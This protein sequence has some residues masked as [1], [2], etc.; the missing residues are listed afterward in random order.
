MKY[1][2]LYISQSDKDCSASPLKDPGDGTY[3]FDQDV[4]EA[5][6]NGEADIFKAEVIRDTIEYRRAHV[7]EKEVEEGVDEPAFYIDDWDLV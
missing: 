6:M 3:G 5:V 1:K 2:L 7:D 4:L